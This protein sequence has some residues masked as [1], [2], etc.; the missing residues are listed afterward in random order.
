MCAAVFLLGVFASMLWSL[1]RA[2]ASIPFLLTNVALSP[3]PPRP[4]RAQVTKEDME[5]YRL[6]KANDDD[7]LGNLSSD[8]LLDEEDVGTKSSKA[9]TK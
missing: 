3:S 1:H 6:T 7:P 5:A 2:F 4:Y 9:K 8:V